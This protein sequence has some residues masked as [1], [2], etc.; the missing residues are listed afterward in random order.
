[1]KNLTVGILMGALVIAQTATAATYYVKPD[2]NN[3][4]DG[5]SHASAWKTTGKVNSFAFKTGDDVYFLA[6]GSWKLQQLKINWSGTAN[7]RAIVG[8]YY[9]NAGKETIGVPKNAGKKPRIIGSYTGPC[10]T[11]GSC[12]DN[13]NAV[14][15]S[16]W[17]GLVEING[18]YVTLQNI[19]VQN[20]AG[21][22]ISVRNDYTH[23]ILENNDVYYT[24][25]NSTIFNR[26]TSNNILRN[27]DLSYC[28]VAWKTGDW[29]V[30]KKQ[31]WPFCNGAV[32]SSNNIFEGNYIHEVY[33]EGLVGLR[34][35]SYNI[36]RRNT[37]VAI[38]SV[39]IYMDSASHNIIENNI[40]IG[41]RDGE[42]T[43]SKASDG[44]RYGGGINN[45][46]EGYPDASDA[47]NNIF[48]NNLL[49]RTGGIS[50]SIKEKSRNKGLKIGAKFLNN[51]LVETSAYISLSLDSQNYAA[52]EIANNVFTGSLLGNRACKITP[53]GVNVHHNHH[54]TIQS[55]AKCN[56]VGDVIGDP[57]LNRTNWNSV[58]IGNVPKVSDFKPK[59]GSSVVAGVT[60]R[61]VI[62]PAN[63][64]RHASNLTGNCPLDFTEVSQDYFCNP[65]SGRYHMG[66]ININSTPRSPGGI[67][68]PTGVSLTVSSSN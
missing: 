22:G 25:A 43:Y 27:N 20:S 28:G 23:A 42:F 15:K 9:M 37:L 36:Y 19:R 21:R 56:G 48:R 68:P 54:D 8:A 34:G 53:T 2:G 3:N 63:R 29:H 40:I 30:P 51:T 17:A 5:K 12:I 65:R 67:K 46:I 47:I 39:G 4:A 66:A 11:K 60:K 52:T 45:W 1:M 33:G 62:I 24:A 10:P 14:P 41:D 16:R 50:M 31:P 58:G 61:K 7:N 32:G 18:N 44:H 35:A 26:R 55:N 57:S 13:A 64:F 38:R 49:V 59:Q 6:G